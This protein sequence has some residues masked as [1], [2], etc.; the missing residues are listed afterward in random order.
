MLFTS[1]FPFFHNVFKRLLSRVRVKSGLWQHGT[2]IIRDTSPYFPIILH[3]VP[4]HFSPRFSKFERNTTSDWLFK[5]FGFSQSVDALLSNFGNLQNK[6][7]D[8]PSPWFLRICSTSLSK[9]VKKGKFA[10]HER[11]LLFPQCFQPFWRTF[12][13]FHTI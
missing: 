3:D 1:I 10:R 9:T 11:F 13:Y 7:K 12:C 8:F 2:N 6:T 4:G 5:V